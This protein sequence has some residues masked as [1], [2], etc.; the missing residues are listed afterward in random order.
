[1]LFVSFFTKFFFMFFV[2]IDDIV[3][4]VRWV[5]Q[6]V[7]DLFSSTPTAEGNEITRSEFILKAGLV[8]STVPVIGMTWGILSG[9]HDYRI[10]RHKVVLKDLP[11]SFNG[12]KIV[13]LSDIHSG[14]FYNKTAVKGGIEMAMKEKGDM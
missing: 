6:K 2:L 12:I 10:R 7:I 1:T 14:S 13:Q 9:A 11:S 5:A 4:V 8:A 3:R